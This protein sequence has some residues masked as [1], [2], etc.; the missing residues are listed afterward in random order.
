[1][2][3]AIVGSGAIGCYYGARLALAGHEVHFLTRRT[4][5]LL[6]SGGIHL[7][8]RER[9]DFLE[10]PRCTTDVCQIGPCDLVVVSLKTTQNGALPG[11][12]PPLL[13]ERTAVLTLQNGL[14]AE[15]FL[16]DLVP[17]EQILG[18]LCYIALNRTQPNRVKRFGGEL[19]VLGE[20][21]R[22]SGKPAE[23][24]ARLLE[25]ALIRVKV[26]PSLLEARWRKLVWNVPFNGLGVAAGGVDT[27]TI[28]NDEV[29]FSQVEPLMREIQAAAEAYGIDIED[30]FL[31]EQIDMTRRMAPYKPSSVVDYLDKREV[32]IEP[33]WGEPVRRAQSRK[34]EVPRLSLL[35]AMI[36]RACQARQEK[37]DQP[38]GQL[39][40]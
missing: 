7:V 34:V 33:I 28:L 3:V 25:D 24:L 19:L 26:A 6:R 15:E 18:G 23:V 31:D 21:N 5:S 8:T 17:G 38:A 1:M 20:Y 37:G 29:L 11:L 27:N 2:K 30:R 32:E 36:R 4:A 14:G 39:N 9:E 12:L 22:P 13:K 40:R 10:E 16:A 35:Y